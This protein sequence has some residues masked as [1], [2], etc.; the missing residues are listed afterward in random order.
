MADSTDSSPSNFTQ[1]QFTPTN[2]TNTFPIVVTKANHG[3]INGQSIRATKF[4]KYPLYQSTG[5]Y[6]LN[7]NLYYVQQVT[8][9]TFQLYNVQGL[10]VDGRSFVPYTSGGQFTLV[11]QD[12][13]TQN[14]APNPPSGV[15][16]F[17]PT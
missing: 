2:I 13:F 4:Y 3:L 7:N 6:Q 10:P 16:P 12:L 15:P 5:M 8:T 17:P 14:P 11:G 1:E 9:N